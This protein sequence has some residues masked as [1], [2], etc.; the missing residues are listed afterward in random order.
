[1]KNILAA[2][3][4]ISIFATDAGANTG[5]FTGSGHTIT[6]T[7]TEQVQLVSEDVA[8]RP[9]CGWWPVVDSVDYRCKF[10]LKNLTAKPLK[11]QVGFP[12]DGQFVKE[13][14]ETPN[15]T[16]LVLDFGFIA[17]D[18]KTTYHVRYV[19]SDSEKKF[20]RLFLW[21]MAF[22]AA[23]T[24][25]LHVVYRIG[26]SEGRIPTR[27]EV[28]APH[29]DKKWHAALDTCIVEHFHYV[30]ETGKSW[31]G[32]IECATFRVE[33]AG[34][35]YCLKQRPL[36]DFDL[37]KPKT[38]QERWEYEYMFPVKAGAVYQHIEP[39]GWKGDAKEGTTSWE[40]RP[41]KAG[42]PIAFLYYVVAIP[43]AATDCDFWVRHVLGK[44]PDKGDLAELREI[45]AAFYGIAPKSESAKKFVEQQ[46]W[47][48]PKVGLQEAKLND[49]QRAVLARLD[50]MAK[51]AP[52]TT[53]AR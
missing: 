9:N 25:V 47:Y 19:A 18:D 30:T 21:E 27:K 28:A 41:Y 36:L 42:P 14:K 26:M 7:K 8:I 13:A 4:L 43:R 38:E 16:D 20:S 24:K 17:R 35:E 34:L 48:H 6:L 2:A 15:A 31:A 44:K 5:Y 46:V 50:A 49:E 29:Y 45:A 10:V 32:P 51:D 22:D 52:P 23:E 39:D 3:F 33:T 37:R 11:I 53:P 12:L 1:M 40:Y